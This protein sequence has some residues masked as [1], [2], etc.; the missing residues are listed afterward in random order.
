MATWNDH[1]PGYNV[2][3]EKASNVTRVLTDAEVKSYRAPADV[4][5]TPE[6]KFGHVKWIDKKAL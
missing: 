5:Q 1:G 3:A 4:F 2:E 6:G